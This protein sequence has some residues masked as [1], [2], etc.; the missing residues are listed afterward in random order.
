VDEL[1][2]WLGESEQDA[3]FLARLRAAAQQWEE[4][5]EAEGLL[6]RDRAAEDAQVWL[7]RQRAE[8]GVHAGLGRREERYLLAVVAFSERARLARRR[9]SVVSSSRSA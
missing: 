8:H 9:I 3:Q 7:T 2:Q 5:Q 1:Q 6:W 4:S